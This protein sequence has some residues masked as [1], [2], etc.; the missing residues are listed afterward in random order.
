M[1]RILV[2]GSTTGVG[3]ATAAALL[4]DGYDV[5]VHAR[6]QQ[7]LAAVEDLIYAG[8][9]SVVGDLADDE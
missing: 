1:T 7:R 4:E 2:T 9:A 6:S 3:R 5:V 8:A